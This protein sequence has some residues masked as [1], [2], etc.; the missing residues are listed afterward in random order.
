MVA[1]AGGVAALRRYHGRSPKPP[2][3]CAGSRLSKVLG[4]ALRQN[5]SP[6]QHASMAHG[7]EWQAREERKI[8]RMQHGHVASAYLMTSSLDQSTVA[9]TVLRSVAQGRLWLPFQSY[10]HGST[11]QTHLD[12]MF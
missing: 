4:E 1:F 12:F 10:L 6:C 5:R 2:P 8:S 3:V 9:L 7:S 11:M